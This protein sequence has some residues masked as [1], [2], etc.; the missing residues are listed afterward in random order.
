MKIDATGWQ[1]RRQKTRD[2]RANDTGL[3]TF[4]AFEGRLMLSTDG[5][6][7]KALGRFKEKLE[8]RRPQDIT[9]N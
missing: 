3:W 4:T 8:G 2:P 7:D 5:R 6:Y 1:K 9:V